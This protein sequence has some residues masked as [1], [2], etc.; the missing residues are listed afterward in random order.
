MSFLYPAFLFALGLIA[1]P[2]IIHLFNFRRYKTVYFSN[3]RFLKEVKEQTT[4]ASKLKHLLVLFA[5]ILV[6]IFAVLAFAQPYIPANE[7]QVTKEGKRAIS[8]YI[9]NSF[10][11]GALTDEEP[12]LNK[13]KR[14]A[15]EIIKGYEEGDIFQLITNDFEARHHRFVS[16]DEMVSLLDEV[17]LSAQV[18]GLDDVLAVQ[19]KDFGKT[20]ADNRIAFWL[21]DYQRNMVHFEEDTTID[22]IQIPFQPLEKSNV[23][24]DSAWLAKPVVFLDQSNELL[25]KIRN[26]S[27]D[28]IEEARMTLALNDEVK[29]L[30]DFSVGG[31]ASVVDTINFS[32]TASGWQRLKV[33]ITDFPVIFDDNFYLSFDVKEQINVLAINEK[34]PSPFF[35]AL[36]TAAEKFNLEN[37]EVNQIKYSAIKNYSLIILND[38]TSIPSGLAYELTQYLEGSGAIVIF[39]SAKLNLESFNSFAGKA[40]LNKMV[41]INDNADQQ[42]A[43]LNKDHEIFRDVFEDVTDNISLPK[44]NLRYTFGSSTQS[45]EDKLLSFRDGG[46]FVSQ[47]DYQGGKVFVCA[48]PLDRNYSDFPLHALFVPMIYK[49]ALSGGYSKKVAYTIGRDEV[50]E[51]ENQLGGEDLI[52]KISGKNNEFI[53]QQKAIGSKVLLTLSDQV[54]KDGVYSIITNDNTD[55][56]ELVALNYNRKESDLTYFSGDELKEKFKSAHVNIIDAT[57]ANFAKIVQEL[58]RG[59]VLWKL[60]I[61]F[62]LMFL[63]MEVLL[64]RFL[65]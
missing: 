63:A 48:S 28:P 17:N 38:V 35:V 40:G 1:I 52:Y 15:E 36:F 22:I 49:M 14:K 18:R 56:V 13:A 62:A 45:N 41:G 8:I 29:A 11:M 42:V 4:S 33:S 27:E 2:I 31:N 55:P 65:R 60:C 61:I 20:D 46:S 6:V 47:Y 16:K 25:V 21:S 64:L 43:Y 59:I 34:E 57:N 53:P 9:D 58:D 50:I 3:V 23:Y 30:S 37:Q 7:A 54:E 44:A 32:V 5:R 51:V 10:S 12:L 39:P 24:I 26:I 19:K